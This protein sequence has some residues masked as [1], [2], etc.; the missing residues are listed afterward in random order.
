M[1]PWQV[2][3]MLCGLAVTAAIVVVLVALTRVV[4]RTEHVLV[5]VEQELRPLIGQ[6][7]GLAEDLRTLT[8]EG[9]REV[10]R[11]GELTERLNEAASGI[12]RVVATLAALTRVG[13]LVGL[14]NG[15][16]KGID[17]FVRRM[18]QGGHH[19]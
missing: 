11:V 16:R 13:Q 15:I 4:R 1:H 9:T 12:I 5:I 3:L 6:V 10:E 8:R 17:V 18:R 2:V 14:A 7:N 19:G